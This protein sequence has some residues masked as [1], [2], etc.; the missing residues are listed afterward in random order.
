VWLDWLADWLQAAAAGLAC[1]LST[2]GLQ[3]ACLTRREA[4]AGVVIE[5]LMNFTLRW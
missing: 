4:D 2:D 5:S 1:H 3:Q